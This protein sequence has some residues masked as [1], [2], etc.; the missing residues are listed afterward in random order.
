MQTFKL[1]SAD[2]LAQASDP[3]GSEVPCCLPARG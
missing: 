1:T 3:E 2:Y